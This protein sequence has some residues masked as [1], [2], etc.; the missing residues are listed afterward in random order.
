M[1][2]VIELASKKEMMLITSTPLFIGEL[3]LILVASINLFKFIT[4]GLRNYHYCSKV[5]TNTKDKL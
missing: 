5:P 1:E 4:N 2:R 3:I